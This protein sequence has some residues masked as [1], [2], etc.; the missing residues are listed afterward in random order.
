MSFDALNIVFFF[1]AGAS[2]PFGI[3]TMKQM[4][5][6]FE[7]ELSQT[8]GSEE[9][10]MYDDIKN[11]LQFDFLGESVDLEAI[12]TVIDGIIEYDI[13]RLGLLSLY[14]SKSHF[15]NLL[16]N[17]K[18]SENVIRTCIGLKTKFQNF[19]REKCMPPATSS[20][21]ISKVYRDFF[22]RLQ[23]EGGVHMPG[24]TKEER[25][26]KYC[27][28]WTMFTTN[29][30]TCL[31]HYWREEARVTLNTGF[32]FQDSRRVSVLTPDLFS[33]EGLK[34]LK[35]HGSISWLFEPDGTIIEEQTV[36]GRQLVFRRFVGE[37]MIYP[38]QQK[39]LYLEPYISMFKEFN[40]ELKRKPIWIIVGY[41]FADPV[42]REVFIR[43]SDQSKRIV[44]IHP[45]A[46]KIKEQKLKDIRCKKM[47]LLNQKFGEEDFTNVNYL[48]IKQFKENPRYHPS[49]TP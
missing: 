32:S 9:R 4:V 49:E 28:T 38:V 24:V 21:K 39:E 26:H 3:P 19:V 29:Y 27:T 43:N 42:I 46:Q 14:A 10:K 48:L 1:G 17:A 13:E 22:N 37:M 5:I 30:D 33:N 6:D 18:P 41:S 34:L 2:A 44:L 45:D 8:G 25:G 36:L 12:F 20:E 35:L 47:S 23:A 7:N 16:T 31:E 40:R 11:I 15:G